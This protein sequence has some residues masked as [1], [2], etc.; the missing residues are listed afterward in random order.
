M[1]TRGSGAGPQPFLWR[2]HPPPVVAHAALT[3]TVFS[4]RMFNVAVTNVPGA[5]VPLYAFGGLLREIRPVMPLLADH[6]VGIAALS[7]NGQVTFGIIADASSM[8]DLDVLAR[9]ITDSL[10]ELRAQLPDTATIAGPS[11]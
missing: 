7:Y 6:A 1:V 11:H 3:R 9:G 10:E 4:R 8:P 5:P 2:R